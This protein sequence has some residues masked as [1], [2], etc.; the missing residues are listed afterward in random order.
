MSIKYKPYY[1]LAGR[2]SRQINRLKKQ[3][4]SQMKEKWRNGKT[5]VFQ[6]YSHKFT[7]L[8]SEEGDTLYQVNSIQYI[9][10]YPLDT[11]AQRVQWDG[12]YNLHSTCSKLKPR[13]YFKIQEQHDITGSNIHSSCSR[14]SKNYFSDKFSSSRQQLSL[15]VY[16]RVTCTQSHWNELIPCM[17]H[18]TVC[19]NESLFKINYASLQNKVFALW[20][21]NIWIL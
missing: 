4:K 15:S 21:Q 12:S 2:E 16:F 13:H 9:M 10:I 7:V 6:T 11:T 14:F 1:H 18:P 19:L 17:R 8:C 5:C 3:S 20:Q